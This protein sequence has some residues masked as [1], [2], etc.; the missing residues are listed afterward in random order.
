MNDMT[1][2]IFLMVAMF[3]IFYFILIRPQKKK[4]KQINDMRNALQVGDEIV[5]IGGI[6]GRVVRI[7][8]DKLVIQSG[9][10]KT[11]IE[12]AKWAVSG[13]ANQEAA[14]SAQKKEDKE[15][16]NNSKPSA[17]SLKKLGQKTEAPAEAATEAVEEKAAEE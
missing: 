14:A 10:D 16:K 5:T 11:K 15:E 2:S 8:D 17:K 1:S 6:Y 3:A 13:P 9:A 12:I 7:N 4:E